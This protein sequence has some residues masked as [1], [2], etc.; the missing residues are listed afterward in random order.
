MPSAA[1]A[2]ACSLKAVISVLIRIEDV[3]LGGSAKG[4]NG[5]PKA[6]FAE[7]YQISLNCQE[8]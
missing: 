4:L 1:H 6:M 8:T 2:G 5:S 3:R 7:L